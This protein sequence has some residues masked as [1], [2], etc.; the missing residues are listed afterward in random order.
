[1]LIMYGLIFTCCFVD[2]AICLYYLSALALDSFQTSSVF[3]GILLT[4][5]VVIICSIWGCHRAREARRLLP[6]RSRRN[7]ISQIF[8]LSVYFVILIIF[9]VLTAGTHEVYAILQSIVSTPFGYWDSHPGPEQDLLM[10]FALEFNDMWVAGGCQGN[11][12][13]FPGCF[14]DPVNLTPLTCT[15]RS[16]EIQ[17]DDWMST[18][19]GTADQLRTC[20]SYVG[21]IMEEQGVVDFPTPTWCECRLMFIDSARLANLIM[22]IFLVVQ[23]VLVGLTIP[24]VLIHTKYVRKSKP[25]SRTDWFGDRTCLQELDWREPTQSSQIR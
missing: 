13:L 25:I 24:V 18:Y 21:S 4:A 8:F 1:L 16:M 23:C 5:T 22:W 17:F 9:V 7:I 10:N 14:G 6:Q 2:I 19:S 12:C 15:D 3:T 20:I 11:T